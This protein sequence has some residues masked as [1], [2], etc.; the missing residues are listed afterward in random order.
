MTTQ[1]AEFTL[2]TK[3]SAP[4]SVVWDAWTNEANLQAWFGPQGCP[5]VAS[6]FN[7]SVGGG[8]HYGIQTP[9]GGTMWGRWVFQAIEP[10]TRLVWEHSFTD[11]QGQT[12]TRHPYCPTWPLEMIARLELAPHGE[13][14]L[15]TIHL[16]AINATEEERQT[17]EDNMDNMRL[18]WGG[19][20]QQLET[21]LASP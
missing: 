18:G 5:I 19:T 12:R 9:D 8:Y 1:T 15:Q 14:T 11:A 17:F 20:F 3:L 6:H 10:Q 4:I 13:K 21:F 7:L 16:H 2:T